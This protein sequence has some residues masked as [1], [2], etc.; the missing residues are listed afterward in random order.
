MPQMGCLFLAQ[1]GDVGAESMCFDGNLRR[2][3]DGR[4]RPGVLPSWREEK[5]GTPRRIPSHYHDATPWTQLTRVPLC[6]ITLS[7]G[8]YLLLKV[9]F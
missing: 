7:L 6:Q 3:K 8:P 5:A 9:Q 4:P 2:G 1:M